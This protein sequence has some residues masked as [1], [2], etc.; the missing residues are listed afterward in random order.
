MKCYSR[1]SIYIVALILTIIGF[2]QTYLWK[3]SELMNDVLWFP[4]G[5]I[6]KKIT[7]NEILM[8]LAAFLQFFVIFEIAYRFSRSPITFALITLGMFIPLV[9]IA[10]L[11]VLDHVSKR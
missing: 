7:G 10:W 1:L 8:V 11:I 3:F 9:G 6:T 2:S 4:L 5:V